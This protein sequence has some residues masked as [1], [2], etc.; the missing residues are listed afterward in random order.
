MYILFKQT[1][2]FKYEGLEPSQNFLS[3]KIFLSIINYAVM[4]YKT[5]QFF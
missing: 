1:R 4:A 3:R 2:P 5:R